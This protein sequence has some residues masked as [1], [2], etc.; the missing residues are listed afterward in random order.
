MK[1]SLAF[2]AVGALAVA[3]TAALAQSKVDQEL[4]RAT[5]V[6]QSLTGPQSE[7]G[8]PD[9]ILKN[10]KCVAVIPRLLQAGFIVGGKHGVGVVTCRESSG[11][12]S[13]PAPFSMSGGSFGL[14]I[15]GESMG[16]VMLAMNDKGIQALMSGHFKVGGDVDAT[17]GPV[18]RDAEAAAGWK[19]A[20]MLSYARS[21]GAYVG[22]TLQGAELNQDH[23]ATKELYG[24]EEGFDAILNGTVA[25]PTETAAATFVHT[26]QHAVV[27]A[28]K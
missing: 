26:V 20:S 13:G 1:K 28:S 22:A 7:A 15:G 23:N 8:I 14:Q 12:W 3:S 10:A 24:Q 2:L 21:K 4:T 19:A 5:E 6:I 18:G 17:A 11:R 9:E 25:M 16:Y 27:R